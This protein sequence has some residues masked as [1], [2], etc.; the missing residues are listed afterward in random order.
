MSK[1]IFIVILAVIICIVIAIFYVKTVTLE[2]TREYV[3]SLFF[4]AEKLFKGTK[5]GQERL[6]WVTHKAYCLLPKYVQFFLSEEDLKKIIN[7]WY[8]AA[9]DV[10]DDGKLNNSIE[11]REGK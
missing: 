7:R 8:L 4:R 9:K 3:Y 11:E 10:L 2:E 1:L 5:K 6:A